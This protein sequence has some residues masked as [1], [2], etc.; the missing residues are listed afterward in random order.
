MFSSVQKK[1]K[2]A[3]PENVGVYVGKD[4]WGC[5]TMAILMLCTQPGS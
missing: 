5:E 4:D 3:V 2:K 1:K